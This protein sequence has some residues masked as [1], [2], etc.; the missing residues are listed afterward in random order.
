MRRARRVSELGLGHRHLTG[1]SKDHLLPLGTHLCRD[2][3]WHAHSVNASP[4]APH[5]RVSASTTPLPAWSGPIHQ[6]V[7][8]LIRAL[9]RLMCSAGSPI[10]VAGMILTPR[11]E[12]SP[13]MER[14]VVP[15]YNAELKIL[16]K[17]TAHFAAIN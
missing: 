13:L 16:G 11:G 17:R 12:S 6:D 3:R 15:A 1:C 2:L 14:G 7:A 10:P 4:P 5:P 8:D 9:R